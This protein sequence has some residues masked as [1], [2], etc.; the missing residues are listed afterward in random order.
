M[1]EKSTSEIKSQLA[2]LVSAGRGDGKKAGKLRDHLSRGATI[3]AS[4]AQQG[5]SGGGT[6]GGGGSASGNFDSTVKRAI[7]TNRNA[8]QPAIQ[9]FQSSIPEITKSFDERGQ[10]LQAEKT[11]LKERFDNL[12]DR[13]Q[14][15]FSQRREGAT[16][17]TSNELGRRGISGSSGIADREMQAAVAPL[18]EQE[19]QA[20]TDIGF[21][22]E[23]QLRALQ[24]AISNLV[25]D[26]TGAL[27]GV[28][29]Q[30]GGL[31]AGAGQSGISN[32]LSLLGMDQQASQFGSNL[33]LQ[34]EAAKTQADQFSQQF[35]LDQQK[36][37]KSGQLSPLEQ[38]LQQAQIDFIKAQQAALENGADGGGGTGSIEDAAGSFN[39]GISNIVNTASTEDIGN[40]G[41]FSRIF[42]NKNNT[43]SLPGNIPLR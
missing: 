32:A 21:E 9:S 3:G 35:G 36:V 34:Q 22:R 42:G 20:V 26:K 37:N 18:L 33:Q 1:A 40:G 11:P 16:L 7:E 15:T 8:I 6:I 41:F 38:M 2:D 39:S 30:I 14:G 12:L 19:G 28:Y 27:R 17:T 23:G 10:Q 24:N 5:S 29:N 43:I 31:E 4:P 25:N 13:V